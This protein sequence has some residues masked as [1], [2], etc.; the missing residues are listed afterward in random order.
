MTVTMSSPKE[1]RLKSA[2]GSPAPPASPSTGSPSNQPGPLNVPA[3]DVE[4]E[5]FAEVRIQVID[6]CV[7]TEEG[8][9][10]TT[11]IRPTETTC[12]SAVT[13]SRK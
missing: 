1:A 12:E 11:V 10:L 9:T 6:R 13:V 7:L 5:A 3:V 4:A 2:E 8:R